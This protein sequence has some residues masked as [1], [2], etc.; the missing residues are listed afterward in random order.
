MSQ[1]QTLLVLAVA[2]SLALSACKREPTATPDS[3]AATATTPASTET[4]DQFIARVNAELKAMYPELTAAQWLSN[5]YI[6]DDSQLLAAKSNEKFLSSLNSWIEQAK[7]FEGQQMSPETARAITLLKLGTS[8]PAPKDPA[9]L[10]E[11]TRIATKMEG[12]YGA[13]S[14][15]KVAGDA[16]SCRQLGELEDV[17]RTSRDYNAQLDAW[18][19]WHT[20]S[21]PMREDYSRFVSLVNEGAKEM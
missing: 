9:K 2:A 5:T 7:R 20:I 4:A 13:G 19:G 14:Y 21:Q 17:L 15:C 18:Q 11:L 8:M 10:A 16:K 3:G 12:M 1:R 6:N